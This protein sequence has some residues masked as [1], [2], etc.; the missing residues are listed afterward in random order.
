M[1]KN[2]NT[3]D[4]KIVRKKFPNTPNSFNWKCVSYKLYFKVNM[5]IVQ[6]ALLI[7]QNSISKSIQSI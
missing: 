6:F 2:K 7:I 3:Y 1:Y 4:I 5:N